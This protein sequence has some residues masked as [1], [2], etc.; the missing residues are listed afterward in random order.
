MSI[1]ES[2]P[3]LFDEI[4][5]LFASCPNRKSLV[6]FKPSEAVQARAR[7]LLDKQADEQL[8]REEERELNELEQAEL[9]MRLVKARIRAA[10]KQ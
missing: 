3:R 5:D 7:V 1:A 10:E 4:A 6:A 8:T 9:V 2:P